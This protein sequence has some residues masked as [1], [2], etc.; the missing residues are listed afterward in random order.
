MNLTISLSGTVVSLDEHVQLLTWINTG[1]TSYQSIRSSLSEN[2]KPF[3]VY[4]LTL[5][6]SNNFLFEFNALY[7]HTI[8]KVIVY[9]LPVI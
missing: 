4:P 9:E 7:M 6:E 8:L 5:S 2:T 3:T 1:C